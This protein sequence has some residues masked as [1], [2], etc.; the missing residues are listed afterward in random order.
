MSNRIV[1]LQRLVPQSVL[2]L[3]VLDLRLPVGVQ[4][5]LRKISQ[6]SSSRIKDLEQDSD[7]LDLM[8]PRLT[9]LQID[10]ALRRDA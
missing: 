3:R 6:R 4:Q 2:H 5:C 10:K 9:F 8:K 7:W 1:Q